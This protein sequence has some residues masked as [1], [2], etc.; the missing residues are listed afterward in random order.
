MPGPDGRRSPKRRT[1]SLAGATLWLAVA[2]AA[3][4][5]APLV[6]MQTPAARLALVAVV[7]VATMLL[8]TSIVAIQRAT[9]MPPATLP[10]RTADERRVMRRFTLVVAA[11]VVLIMV[12]NGICAAS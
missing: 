10:P 4:S 3:F 11:E 2:G 7:L 8:A 6:W 12:I 9:R 1:I 5:I